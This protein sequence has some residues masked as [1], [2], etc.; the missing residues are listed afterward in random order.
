MAL[1]RKEKTFSHFKHLCRQHN[2]ALS[3]WAGL[4]RYCYEN[5]L[6]GFVVENDVGK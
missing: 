2:S 3:E 5:Q 1:H 6:G 4:E